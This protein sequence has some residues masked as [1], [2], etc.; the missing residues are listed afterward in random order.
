MMYR[1]MV[2][3]NM[4]N[5][6]TANSPY[7]TN[8]KRR[9]SNWPCVHFLYQNVE[10]A[11]GKLKQQKLKSDTLRLMMNTAVALRTWNNNK[12][13]G[14]IVIQS[15]HDH[16]KIIF[17]NCSRIYDKNKCL[18]RVDFD[19]KRTIAMDDGQDENTLQVS[20]ATGR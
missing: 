1:F 2:I 15:Y 9:Q 3:A 12:R 5:K 17:L 4:V 19:I 16:V 10:A 13:N 18:N 20:R 8:G 6:D 11:S 14:S 7:L